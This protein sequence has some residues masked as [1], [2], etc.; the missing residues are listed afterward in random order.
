MKNIDGWD[1]REDHEK[2]LS[3]K[4]ETRGYVIEPGEE[5][6]LNKMKKLIKDSFQSFVKDNIAGESNNVDLS[7][8]HEIINAS[9]NNDLRLHII[10]E[11]S[12]TTEFNRLYY[13]AAKNIIEELC[14]NELAM[15]KRVGLSINLPHNERD[16]LPIHAD[17]WNGVSPYELNIW[18]PFVNCSQSMSLYILEKDKYKQI[19]A[20]SSELLKLN[21]DEI[22]KELERHLTWIEIKYGEILAFDQSLPHGYTK[23]LEKHTHWSLNCRF[24]GLH[25]PY[26]DKRL[27]E[28]FM[29]ITAK[30]CTRIGIGYEYPEEWL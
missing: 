9:T 15:Q 22:F 10:Q 16:I 1:F 14:G 30:C 8:S 5:A 17:T 25:T 6:Y 29:P 13:L 11:I 20:S 4:F 12:Q 26:W 2:I 24:K 18:I 21:S 28:Y 23:N 27:G 3:S 7:R 19:L